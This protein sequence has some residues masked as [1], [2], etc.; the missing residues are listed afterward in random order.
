MRLNRSF[1]LDKCPMSLVVE[2][3]GLS[4]VLMGDF[5]P[6]IFQPYW[7]ASEKLLRKEEAES[8]DV[9]VV[10]SRVSSFETDWLSIQVTDET[11]TAIT[12]KTSHYEPLRDLVKG[13]FSLLKHTPISKVGV[14]Q[15]FHYQCESEESWN[16][17]GDKLVPKQKWEGILNKP[18]LRSLVM[19]E[20]RSEEKS[21]KR[22][23]IEPSVKIKHG[24]FIEVGDHHEFPD[25]ATG[26]QELLS[27]LD[28]RWSAFL[29]EVET[30]SAGL[31]K[32]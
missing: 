23:K 1:L 17:F 3:E 32:L 29:A 20:K 14:N 7:F 16:A 24:I 9:K 27:V 13:T 25:K 5:N 8:A 28:K 26:A 2:H 19:E 22:I 21:F 31:L 4:I 10:H 18:G 15:F 6:K 11:L 30:I 12:T